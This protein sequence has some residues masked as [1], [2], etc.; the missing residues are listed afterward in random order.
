[1]GAHDAVMTNQSHTRNPFQQGLTRNRDGAILGGVA[2]GL[3]SRFDMSPSWIRLGFIIA[4]FFGGLGALLYLLGWVA[5]PEE[6]KATSIAE[7]FIAGLS[8]RSGWLGAGLIVLAGAILIGAAGLFSG[9]F[10]LAS[11]LL[12]GGYLLYRG[13]EDK[14]VPGGDNPP[15][16]PP[17]GPGY[18]PGPEFQLHPTPGEPVTSPAPALGAAPGPEPGATPAY[19]S[20]PVTERYQGATGYRTEDADPPP[21]YRPP[22]TDVASPPPPPPPRAPRPR[23]YLGRLTMACLLITIGI[24]ALLRNVDAVDLEARHFAAAGMLVVGLGLLVGTFLGRA[25]GLILVGLLAVPILVGATAIRVPLNGEWGRE[26]VRPIGT[27]ELRP[28]YQHGGGRLVFDLTGVGPLTETTTV[29][30]EQG[31]GELEVLVPDEMSVSIDASVAAGAIEIF[32]RTADDGLDVSSTYPAE[33]G[34]PTLELELDLGIGRISVA[35]SS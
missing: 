12:L 7:D 6:G 16:A 29:S 8:D 27:A 17:P 26:T 9:P 5:I 20:S 19:W 18:Q 25:R 32:D 34:E 24:L 10:V 2:G 31:I 21:P 4:T 33:P 11:G 15:P 30:I 14:P 13:Q 1:M 35:R 23:S 22:P 28:E 3:A